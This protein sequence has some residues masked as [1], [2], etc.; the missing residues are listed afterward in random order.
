MKAIFLAKIDLIK[1][2]AVNILSD[3]MLVNITR[4]IKIGDGM[5][6]F[7]RISNLIVV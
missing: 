2:S 1:G 4:Y 3:Y 7:D 6:F 5:S